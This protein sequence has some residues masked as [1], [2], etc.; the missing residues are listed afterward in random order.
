MPICQRL[1]M[2][3][4]KNRVR[5]DV[6][7]HTPAYT[8]QE[9]AA[10][11]HIRGKDL[12]KCIMLKGDGKHTMVAM[13]ANQKLN[14]DK[15]RKALKVKQ[16][17]LEKEEEFMDLFDDCEPGAMPP[18][19]NLYGVPIV[20]DQKVYEDQTIAFNCGDHSSIVRMQFADFVKLVKPKKAAVADPS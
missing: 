9:I 4:D 16:A 7:S 19:G 20:V 5:Y 2:F 17:Y 8:A 6:V 13:T 15:F 11:T 18:F 3:L 1:K 12:I 14:M 10:S